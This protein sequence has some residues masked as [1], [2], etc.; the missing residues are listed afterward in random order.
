MP[1]FWKRL[2]FDL[3]RSHSSNSF[4]LFLDFS[5][6]FSL[7]HTF[8]LTFHRFVEVR[9]FSLILVCSLLVRHHQIILI[10]RR[11]FSKLLQ[12]ITTPPNIPYLTSIAKISLNS[13]KC[14]KFHYIVCFACRNKSK[15]RIIFEIDDDFHSKAF[16]NIWSDHFTNF[17]F[18]LNQFFWIFS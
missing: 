8:P 13:I 15:L 9:F 7:T 17:S 12:Y 4:S 3:L 1:L 11:W 18:F 2:S 5:I 14:M 16:R 10:I 6:S